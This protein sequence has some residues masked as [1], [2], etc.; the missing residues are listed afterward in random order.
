MERFAAQPNY[1]FGPSPPGNDIR[2][3][4]LISALQN[5]KKLFSFKDILVGKKRNL[6]ILYCTAGYIPVGE[7][8]LCSL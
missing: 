6:N 2:H 4:A 3:S 8:D 7:A 5:S 1:T